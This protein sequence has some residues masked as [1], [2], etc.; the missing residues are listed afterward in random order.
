V[1]YPN[2][3]RAAATALGAAL[4]RSGFNEPALSEMLG[5]DA[6]GN[7]PVDVAVHER[8]LAPTRLGT[9]A[10]A[11]FLQLPVER[12][13][14]VGA[15]GQ[16][17]VDALF[18]I[19]IAEPGETIRPRARIMPVGE[20]LVLADDHPPP[21][22]D[23]PRDYVAAYTPTSRLCDCLTPRR[24]GERVL[25]VGTG[26][27]VQA[28]L[29]A[30]HASHVIATD[31][32]PRALA[33]ADTNAALNG[34][35]NVET[36]RGSFFDAV[37][38]E[39]FDLI[40]CNTPYVVSPEN[41]FEYRDSGLRG[42]EV[43]QLV[44]R[45]AAEHLAD[46][47]YATMTGSWLGDDEESADQRPYDWAKGLRDCDAWILSVWESDPLEHAASW[48]REH[49]DEP[50]QLEEAI[51]SW[52]GYLDELNAGWVSE[53]VIALHKR[54]GKRHGVR[55][56]GVDEDGLDEAGDQVRRA[57][58][59]RARLTTTDLLDE[60]PALALRVEL[61]HEL[62]RR[63]RAEARVQLVEGTSSTIETT[64][65]ALAIVE[66]LDGKTKL[67]RLLRNADDGTRRASVR[68]VRELA[69]LGA[70]RLR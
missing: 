59:N 3:D 1:A 62:G 57:F 51:T 12:E 58:E 7:D 24:R 66:R 68:L 20:L 46:D 31:V 17:A 33:F 44:M 10:R 39:R 36:R 42:D 49:A 25:D 69:E 63:G 35:T 11:L 29:A 47:G 13:R 6:W 34:F 4:R 27:G 65:A 54:P 9:V 23:V 37:E 45:S 38:G 40:T 61:E 2:F 16:R 8:R 43:T 56:D 30:R 32:N 26:S 28:I 18:T 50:E 55:V 67:R 60:R 53:G 64:P 14:L 19:E 21:S 48:N 5:D 70:L 52:S 15:L 41:R 22:A